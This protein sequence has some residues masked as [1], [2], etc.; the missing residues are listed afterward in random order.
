MAGIAQGCPLS[1]YLFIAVQTVML[2]NALGSIAYDADPEYIV[3]RD[4]LY[5]DD[6]LLASQSGRNLQNMLNAIVEEWANYTVLSL[7][8]TKHCRCKFVQH[9]PMWLHL[10]WHLEAK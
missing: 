9:V 2:H 4:T 1:P 7:T 3:T 5:A 6:T 10:N 8:G